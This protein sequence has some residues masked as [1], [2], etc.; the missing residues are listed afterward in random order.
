MSYSMVRRRPVV[1]SLGEITFEKVC[2]ELGFETGSDGWIACVRALKAAG[3]TTK[4][5]PDAEIT[6]K[7]PPSS[8]GNEPYNPDTGSFNKYAGAIVN[9][10]PGSTYSSQTRQTSTS[11]PPM[12]TQTKVAAAAGAGLLALLLLL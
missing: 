4:P 9:R 8:P 5:D 1:R 6:P 12:A 3:P 2:Q 11:R 7:N 10:P